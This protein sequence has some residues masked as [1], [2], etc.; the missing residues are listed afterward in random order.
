MLGGGVAIRYNPNK[1]RLTYKFKP[2]NA[3]TAF[4][5][6]KYDFEKFNTSI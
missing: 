6:I 2:P 3:G 1:R 5:I 4:T